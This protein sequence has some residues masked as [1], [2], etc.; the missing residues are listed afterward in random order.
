MLNETAK[1]T[2][3]VGRLN[4]LDSGDQRELAGLTEA[5]TAECI[6][7]KAA[8]YQIF[9]S[10]PNESIAAWDINNFHAELIRLCNLVTEK[11]QWRDDHDI[12]EVMSPV[13][14]IH[15]LA[16]A[17]YCLTDMVNFSENCFR[18]FVGSWQAV[19]HF[20]VIKMRAL[21]QGTWPAIEQGLRKKRISFWMIREISSGLNALVKR[22]YPAITY[23]DHDYIQVFL[24]ELARLA[25]DPRKKNWEQR[26]LYFLNHYN[27]NHMG[28]FNHWTASF[29]KR[30]E[31]PVEVED[32]IRLIDNTKH[33]F[34]HTSGL[35]HLA[36]DPGSDTLNAHIL[37]F[38]DEQR[39][40]ISGRSTSSPGAVKLK[41]RLSADELSLEFH[42][43]YRQNLFNY[44]T[45]K[46]A[47]H[48]FAAVHSSSQ[49]EEISAHTIGRLD[50]KRLFSSAVKY[51]RILLTIDKQI[52]EDFDIEGKDSD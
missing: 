35:K 5:I 31:A 48:D 39:M 41:M 1:L 15:P 38:L 14:D 22:S 13:G 51:H 11:L 43:K 36:F 52:R 25:S 27:F 10:E 40:L 3:L 18:G 44:Q 21:L 29:R 16:Y 12:V 46:E 19:P 32:K 33:L 34:S 17:L 47:A 42:Y 20:C 37:L 28:F 45:R 23:R 9:K 6:R 4:A 30:L 26:L 50:K 2:S 8:V 49:T 7:L 24:S